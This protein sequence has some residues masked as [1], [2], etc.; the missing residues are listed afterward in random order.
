M[1]LP[2]HVI[3]FGRQTKMAAV[4]LHFQKNELD[5]HFFFDFSFPFWKMRTRVTNSL[6]WPLNQKAFTWADFPICRATKR[7]SRLRIIIRRIEHAIGKILRYYCMC[8]HSVFNNIIMIRHCTQRFSPREHYG[9]IALL[10]WWSHLL[11]GARSDISLK[12][13]NEVVVGNGFAWKPLI[14]K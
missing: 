12:G 13:I 9:E 1:Q 7:K 5:F 6:C 4:A 10:R 11:C 14:K 8:M 3:N 2:H